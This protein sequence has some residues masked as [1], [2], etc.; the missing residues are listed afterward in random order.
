MLRVDMH[1]VTT[2]KGVSQKVNRPFWDTPLFNSSYNILLH[3]GFDSRGVVCCPM[4][5]R[6]VPF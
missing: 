3:T 4:R 2:E 5:F 6:G 1:S